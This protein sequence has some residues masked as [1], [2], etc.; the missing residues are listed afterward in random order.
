MGM[1]AEISHYRC[2]FFLEDDMVLKPS[3][4]T[5]SISYSFSVCV[6]AFVGNSEETHLTMCT[7]PEKLSRLLRK[8]H[9]FENRYTHGSTI[10]EFLGDCSYSFQGSVKLICIT[11]TL[12]L[13]FCA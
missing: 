10:F 3:M 6:L 5:L 13:L 2:R 7:H 1:V 8:D 11:V 9:L 4:T 12:S